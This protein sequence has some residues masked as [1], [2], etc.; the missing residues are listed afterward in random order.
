V[1]ALA[2]TKSDPLCTTSITYTLDEASSNLPSFITVDGSNN[3]IVD[4]SDTTEDCTIYN[5]ELDGV[6]GADTAQVTFD[7]TVINN[8]PTLTPSVVAD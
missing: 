4:S 6:I 2:W 8:D 1:Q 7:M 3:L 5:M